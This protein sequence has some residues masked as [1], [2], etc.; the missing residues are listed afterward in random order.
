M[1]QILLVILFQSSL[2]ALADYQNSHTELIDT[3]E[4]TMSI[5]QYNYTNQDTIFM[6]FKV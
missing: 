4:Y 5:D 1:K 6:E 3:I 2:A